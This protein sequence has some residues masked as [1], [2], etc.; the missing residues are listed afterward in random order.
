M[1]LEEENKEV[2]FALAPAFIP[3]G[4]QRMHESS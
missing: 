4:N 1:K 3:I 2:D